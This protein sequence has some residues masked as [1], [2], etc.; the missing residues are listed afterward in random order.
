MAMSL[1]PWNLNRCWMA[2]ENARPPVRWQVVT[3]LAFMPVRQTV[4]K[5]PIA[6]VGWPVFGYS[7][8]QDSAP[9]QIPVIY[10]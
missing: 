6:L 8:L 5:I 10:A 1:L 7:I 9:S 4:M 3:F 2:G